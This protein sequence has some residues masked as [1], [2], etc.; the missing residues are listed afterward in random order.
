[1]VNVK[2]IDYYT[3][4]DILEKWD[5]VVAKRTIYQY[6]WSGKLKKAMKHGRRILFAR[7]EINRFENNLI[8]AGKKIKRS[9]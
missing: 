9:Q 8:R 1:M 2:G 5:N 3:I 6:V 7:E 4:D